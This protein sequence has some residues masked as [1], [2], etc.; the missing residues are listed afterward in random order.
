MNDDDVGALTDRMDINDLCA[1]YAM[2]LSRH[3]LDE[4][5]SLFTPDGVYHA[6]GEEY[7]M[8]VLPDLI[9]AAPRGQL[10][11]NT[12]L[13]ELDGDQASGSQNYVFIAQQTHEMR[14]AWYDD[15]YV[16]TEEGWRFASRATTFLRRSGG[17]D[18]G[19]A[20][21]PVRPRVE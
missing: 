6:F 4:I 15:V 1:R 21:D 20:H 12:P 3:L 11:V 9:A 18:S 10:I 14:L 8:E 19:D 17:F 16:R 7:S 5:V 2:C 13:I